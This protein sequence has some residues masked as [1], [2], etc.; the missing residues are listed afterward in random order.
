[1]AK[2]E[3]GRG[4]PAVLIAS[5]LIDS[6]DDEER[7]LLARVAGSA[8][9]VALAACAGD[10]GLRLAER[11]KQTVR[12]DEAEGRVRMRSQAV[13]SLIQKALA[14]S[15]QSH[16]DDRGSRRRTDVLAEIVHHQAIGDHERALDLF[17]SA[18]GAFFT[19]LNGL[20]ACETV[21]AG[22]PAE[23][24]DTT[25]TLVLADAINA[26]KSGD[27]H[28]ARYLVSGHFQPSATDFHRAIG[29]DSGHTLEFLCFRVVMAVYEEITITDETLKRLFE[30]LGCYG[31]EAH[32]FR[33][34]FY[35]AVLDMFVRRRMLAEA[36]EACERALHHFSKARASLLVFYIH[37]YQAIL[38][39]MRG[40]LP[41]VVRSLADAGAALGKAPFATE[42]DHLLL[43]F[44]D[45]IVKYEQGDPRPL[46]GF[47]GEKLDRLA[48]GEIWPTVAELAITYGSSAV[49]V[50]F[51]TA[52]ARGFLDRW[53]VQE[54]RSDRFRLVL[55]L[56]EVAI[57]QAANRWSEAADLLAA[58][59]GRIDRAW[60][61]DATVA[62]A[63]LPDPDDIARAL[64]WLRMAVHE[65]PARPALGDQL[66]A[67]LGND[68]LTHSQR[69]TLLVWSAYAAR[70]RRDRA[71]ARAYLLKAVE[72]SGR[73][74]IVTP[75][76]E[77][78]SFLKPLLA[79]QYFHVFLRASAVARPA[80]KKLAAHNA[81]VGEEMAKGGLTRQE[82]RVLMLVAEGGSNKHVARTLGLSVVTV[83]YH[84]TNVYRK[85]GCRNRSEAISTAKALNWV[86]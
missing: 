5:E 58:A 80:L 65:S 42:N 23:L 81:L 26:L 24:R 31:L 20:R 54:W 43:E 63:V 9:G 68:R 28:R 72:A 25:D 13:A 21:L 45:A 53:R 77:Q 46:L 83:K 34:M 75:L 7:T 85:L 16:G 66:S 44:L 60:V 82:C 40:F 84:L 4:S 39:L 36:E 30:L 1:M 15:R 37:V 6:L 22:F 12:I 11:L 19:H 59:S 14:R 27:L 73:N 18:G 62:L 79:D 56:R 10:S 57:L 29:D 48:H 38:G 33:G 32:L 76:L 49:A 41:Q 55:T 61:E 71:E 70:R 17:R 74:G 69:I 35:N 64:T 8:D 86:S 2:P 50:H 67:A 3:K 78:L 47:I 52:A 51:T